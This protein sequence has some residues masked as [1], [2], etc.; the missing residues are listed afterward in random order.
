M[1]QFNA[2]FVGTVFIAA[3]GIY[4]HFTGRCDAATVA[5]F[6]KHVVYLAQQSGG[7]WV[8]IIT[9]GAHTVYCW[10]S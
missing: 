1:E 8:E 10:A 3:Q 7:T 6:T 2:D 9:N 5:R 4:E